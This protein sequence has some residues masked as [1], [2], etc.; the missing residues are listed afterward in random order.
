MLETTVKAENEGLGKDSELLVSPETP[1]KS[2]AITTGKQ[3]DEVCSL[4]LGVF[5]LK[6]MKF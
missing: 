1:G 4:N 5:C 2:A 6:K 3:K